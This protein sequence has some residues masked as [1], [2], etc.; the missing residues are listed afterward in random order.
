MRRPLIAGNWKLN[1]RRADVEE[2][3][4]A[5]RAGF[6]EEWVEAVDML[7]CPPAVFLPSCESSLKGSPI[8]WG[9]QSHAAEASGAYTGEV[10]ASMIADFGASYAIVGHS[11]RR[12]LFAETDAIVAQKVNRAVAA[13][14]TPIV[15][16]GETLDQ[17]EAGE[18]ETVICSQ[19][20]A[21]LSDESG[22]LE[23]PFVVAYEPVWAIGTGKVASV[24]DVESVLAAIRRVL[25]E[26]SESLSER[27]L[28]LYGGSVK[29]SNTAELCAL[30][31]L[32]GALVGGASLKPADFLEIMNQCFKSLS[33]ST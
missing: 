6:R 12:A 1:G 28:L 29:P 20:L 23:A 17:R 5:L 31:D 7:V 21:A 2:R 22:F 14:L 24:A 9:S 11:E 16:V 13:G 15:C 25:K 30:P 8:A 3:L 32:D 27:T 10:S 4:K 26:G 19:L 33:S 18:A